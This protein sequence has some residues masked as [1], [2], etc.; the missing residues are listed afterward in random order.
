M[1]AKQSATD[2]LA[3]DI[4]GTG[5]KAVVLD[6][7]GRP[8]HER[9]RISTTYPCPPDQLVADLRKLVKDLPA[10]GRAAAGFPGVVRGGKVL[11]APHFVTRKGPGSKVD[12]GLLKQ[13]DRFDLTSALTK[14][15]G[16]PV[17]VA[18]DADVQGLGVITGKGVELVLTL[19]TG[20]GSA[21]FRDGRLAQHL[22]LAHHPAR[23]AES[24]N[25][26]VGNDARESLGRKKWNRRVETALDDL[27][28]LLN[29]DGI[30]IG[31]G[32]AEDIDL[33]QLEDRRPHLAAKIR[34]VGNDGGLLGGVRLWEGD[35]GGAL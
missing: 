35:G 29:P 24:Y 7:S 14:A 1:A 11:T 16:M 3:I 30:L 34:L 2:T 13:W 4:G 26:A 9:V 19:G 32:N 31:G 6:R 17:R 28:S 20:L 22:E 27:D 8:K 15:L 18:N 33:R 10:A 21:V 5:L 12:R 23:D 25:L